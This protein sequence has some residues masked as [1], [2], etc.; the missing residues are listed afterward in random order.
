MFFAGSWY[1]RVSSGRRDLNNFQEKHAGRT[2]CEEG[3]ST[4]S[5]NSI[6]G[7]RA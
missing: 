3:S 4:L 6:H 5:L 2:L 1:L 7:K